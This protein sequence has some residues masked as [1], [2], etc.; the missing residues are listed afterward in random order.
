M[1]K[2]GKQSKARQNKND[3]AITQSRGT[4]QLPPQGPVDNILSHVLRVILQIL[5]PPPGGR[6]EQYAA[7]IIWNQKVENVDSLLTSCQRDQKNIQ[8]LITHPTPSSPCLYKPFP[9][10]FKHWLPGLLTQHS[11]QQFTLY[12]VHTTTQCQ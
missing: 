8:E 7:Q 12:L 6:S 2:K 4:F 10:S 1:Q 3:L 9:E 11:L 5:K